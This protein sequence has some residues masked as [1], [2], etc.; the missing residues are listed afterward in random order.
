MTNKEKTIE[1]SDFEKLVK[2]KGRKLNNGVILLKCVFVPTW[3]T[4]QECRFNGLC[5]KDNKLCFQMTGGGWQYNNV[6]FIYEPFSFDEISFR[7]PD[8]NGRRIMITYKHEDIAN[9]LT[10]LL[11]TYCN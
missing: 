10:K 5:I 3:D 6:W 2:S 9:F 4:F 7:Y 8:H 1:F 11:E